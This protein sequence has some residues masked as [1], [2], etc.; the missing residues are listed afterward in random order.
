MNDIQTNGISVAVF[1]ASVLIGIWISTAGIAFAQTTSDATTTTAQP[2]ALESEE[3]SRGLLQRIRDFLTGNTPE[4]EDA[5]SDDTAE[6]PVDTGN[7][8]D[9][10]E[11]ESIGSDPIDLTIS[12]STAPGTDTQ[13]ETW[14]G[15]STPAPMVI[16]IDEAGHALVRGSVESVS[17]NTLTITSWGKIWTIHT[18][19][20]SKVIPSVEG[21]QAGD[22]SAISTGDFVGAE[23]MLSTTVDFT[24]EADLVRDWTTHPY[25]QEGTEVVATIPL[26]S[27]TVDGTIPM[28]AGTIGDIV[29]ETDL[30]LAEIRTL[31]EAYQEANDEE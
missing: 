14:E 17:Q 21:A 22:L 29:I 27:S 20:Q 26:P 6:E 15:I 9:E 3:D 24:I 7:I 2:E 11:E 19:A 1:V 16:E 13:P 28:L 10:G 31:I 18:D 5:E 25:P 30:T 4:E 8:T 12:T 23:G